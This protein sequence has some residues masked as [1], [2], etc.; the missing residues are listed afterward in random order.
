MKQRLF[1]IL[2]VLIFMSCK[3]SFKVVENPTNYS[4]V[5]KKG[6]LIGVIFSS[7]STCFLCD[8]YK[9]RFTPTLEEIEKAENIITEKIKE[10]NN[11]IIN[12]GN[13]CP[14][15]HKNLNHYRRQYFGYV[16]VNGDKI[17]ETLFSWNC[18]SILDKVR[19]CSKSEIEDWKQ[20]KNTVLDGCSHHWEVSI[21]LNKEVLFGLTI[22][23]IG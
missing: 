8:S 11:P 17:I 18:F 14:I 19:G 12:Q 20:E 13:D 7:N 22:N 15:I 3:T 9:N 1:F 21:N 16:D 4:T 23:G 2:V 10:L 6:N 5:I